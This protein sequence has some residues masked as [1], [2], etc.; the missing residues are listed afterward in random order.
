MSIIIIIMVMFKRI[1]RGKWLLYNGY[2]QENRQ[3]EMSLIIIMVIF[4][5]IDRG[6]CLLYNGY[7]QE[8][9]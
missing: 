9:R 4:K 2:I 1:N 8:N 3:G 5:R 7:I 6:K